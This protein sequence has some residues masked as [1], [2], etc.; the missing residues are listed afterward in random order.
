MEKPIALS[1][2]EWQSLRP[3]GMT[4]P[5]MIGENIT[6][7]LSPETVTA[8]RE[9]KVVMIH[10]FWCVLARPLKNYE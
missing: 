4:R 2:E 5:V 6:K 8:L 1:L 3:Y 9:G 10:G 7:H